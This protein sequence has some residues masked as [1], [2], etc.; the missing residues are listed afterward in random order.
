[1]TRGSH[2]PLSGQGENE[3]VDRSFRLQPIGHGAGY[4]IA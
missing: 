3:S 4:T 2:P 1:M